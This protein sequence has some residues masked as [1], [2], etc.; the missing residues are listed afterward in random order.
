MSYSVDTN[1]LIYASDESSPNHASA[2]SFLEERPEDPD[3]FCLTWPVLM[4][5]QRI[6]THP[7][8]F[9]EPLSPIEA[10]KN[11]EALLQLPRVRLVGESE[12]FIHDYY[13]V[14]SRV[15]TRGNLVPD[16]HVATIL[17]QHGIKLIYTA[18]ADF[19]KFDFLKAVNPLG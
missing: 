3:L 13:K 16:A 12:D 4:G 6:A 11:I 15:L 18:D 19:L 5:Y 9:R 2:K 10:W 1:I 8:I 7:S 17:R 14:T